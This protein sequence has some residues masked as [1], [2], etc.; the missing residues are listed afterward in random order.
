MEG[1]KFKDQRKKNKNL[2]PPTI[3]EHLYFKLI[4][5]IFINFSGGFVKFLAVYIQKQTNNILFF[6]SFSHDYF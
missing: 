5:L 1:A 3:L 2:Y 4:S 6:K